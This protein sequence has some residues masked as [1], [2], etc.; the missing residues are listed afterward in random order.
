MILE[1]ILTVRRRALERHG[2]IEPWLASGTAETALSAEELMVLFNLL[3]IGEDEWPP[4]LE[5]LRNVGL[6]LPRT[7]GL[8]AA[9][10]FRTMETLCGFHF[11]LRRPSSVPYIEAAWN[12]NDQCFPFSAH[13]SEQRFWFKLS[14]SLDERSWPVMPVNGPERS[15]VAVS[16]VH[17]QTIP[18]QDIGHVIGYDHVMFS[19]RPFLFV[20]MKEDSLSRP[21]AQELRDRIVEAL[22]LPLEVALTVALKIVQF[23]EA[24]TV[25][26]EDVHRLAVALSHGAG[27]GLVPAIRPGGH[28]MKGLTVAAQIIENSGLYSDLFVLQEGGNFLRMTIMFLTH[29]INI[30]SDIEGLFRFACLMNHSC[31][32]NVVTLTSGSK[33]GFINTRETSW[34]SSD[35]D[36]RLLGAW[37]PVR[38]IAAGEELTMTYIGPIHGSVFDRRR[39]ILGLFGF[40]CQC[41]RCQEEVAASGDASAVNDALVQLCCH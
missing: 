32:P 18:L 33:N 26:P 2:G 24:L 28:Y 40:L 35:I 20:S 29:P 4:I 17:A 27:T 25:A 10:A 14:G 16:A 41:S 22:T 39:R 30:G 7:A 15:L 8:Q 36:A 34:E 3:P 21:Q 37:V 9:Q 19:E 5:C 23:F 6:L 12:L 11:S 31:N 13:P 38:P 1:A